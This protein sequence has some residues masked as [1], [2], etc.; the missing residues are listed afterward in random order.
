MSAMGRELLYAD[1]RNGWK[2]TYEV[3]HQYV[4]LVRPNWRTLPLARSFNDR[5]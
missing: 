2:R 1:G 3:T 4:C 5:R